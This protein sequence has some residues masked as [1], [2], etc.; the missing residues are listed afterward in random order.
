MRLQLVN[1]VH[2]TQDYRTL[3]YDRNLIMEKPATTNVYLAC[4]HSARPLTLKGTSGQFRV[5]EEAIEQ[6]E[7][8]YDNGDDPSFYVARRG[9]RLTWGVCR[10]D[11]RNA[12][13]IGSVVV[14]FSFTPL[15]TGETLYRL[16]AVTTVSQRVDHRAIHCDPDLRPFQQSYI[17][18]LIRPD[19][20]GWRY[21]EDD[22]RR[23][24]R[25]RDWL[26]RIAHHCGIGQASFNR[27]FAQIYGK[28][29]FDEADL[30]EGNLLLTDNYIVFSSD[31]SQS[32]ISP[33]PPEVAVASPGEHET[34]THQT[35][36][37]M[38]VAKAA[39][40]LKSGRDFLRV[41]NSS[42]RNVHRQIRCT[43]PTAEAELWREQ[44]IQA[45]KGASSRHKGTHLSR[46]AVRARPKC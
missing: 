4:Y 22:R 44:L 26:W 28:E 46:N 30:N 42:G 27:R 8:P 31:A 33:K 36:R 43:L 1:L 15:E 7:W 45:L 11:L 39:T 12:I 40:A 10:Q 13:R 16:C 5:V 21:D 23:D 37:A 14:F 20:T 25:H 18:S 29:R 9:G 3:K 24:Q 34:W 2:H 6:D 35:F 32:F 41:A 17:N 19:A 38:T